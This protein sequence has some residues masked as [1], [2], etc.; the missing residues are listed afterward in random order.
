MIS[1]QSKSS[2]ESI[3]EARSESEDE[4]MTAAIFATRSKMFAITFI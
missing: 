4:E 3:I 1:V 2:A